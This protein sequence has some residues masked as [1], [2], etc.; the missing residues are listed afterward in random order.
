MYDNMSDYFN[1]ALSKFQCGFRRGFGAQNSLLYMKETIRKTRDNH[2]VFVA[3]MT[4]LSKAF[5]C[6]SHELLIA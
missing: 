4:A 5:D 6:I 3:V 2:G 1:D